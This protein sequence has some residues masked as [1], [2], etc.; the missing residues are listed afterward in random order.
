MQI[1]E[2]PLKLFIHAKNKKKEKYSIFE[3]VDD[4]LNTLCQI[5]KLKY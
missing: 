4:K 3:E 5:K 2:K 1:K